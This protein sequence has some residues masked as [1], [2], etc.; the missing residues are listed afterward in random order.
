MAK[1]F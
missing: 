1:Y